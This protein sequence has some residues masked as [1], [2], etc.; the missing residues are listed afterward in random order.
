MT[1]KATMGTIGFRID[2]K[3]PAAIQKALLADSNTNLKSVVAVGV[4]R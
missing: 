1:D 2:A 4:G 3:L